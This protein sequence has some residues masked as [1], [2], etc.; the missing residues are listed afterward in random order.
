MSEAPRRPQVLE[1]DAPASRIDHE[2]EAFV[3]RPEASESAF[4]T[5]M[6]IATALFVL[7][8]GFFVVE[9]IGWI[10]SLLDTRPW[11]GWTAAGV[12]ALG[13]L[14]LLWAI[15]RE[16]AALFAVRRIE[17]WQ[18]ALALDA[19]DM[20]KARAAAQSYIALI[21]GNGIAIG[22]ARELVRGA[23]S[24]EGIRNALEKTV[25]P[26]LDKRAAQT[27][28]A[29]AAQ[30]FGMT[31]MSPSASIDALLFSLRGVRLVRQVARAYGL[32]PHGLATWELL[33][34]TMSSASLVAAADI[35]GGMLSHAILTNP[36]AAKIAG[37]VAGAAVASQRMY[38]L[39]NIASAACRLF[40]KRSGT[41]D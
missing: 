14:I 28:R 29:A 2:W 39:G 16:L 37:E 30:S 4:G 3:Q 13:L 23:N 38:R 6:L 7:V 31:A 33:R 22:D 36:F 26:V 25:L 27:V 17:E 19:E 32:R 40:P 35:A 8:V 9:S 15:W 5:G 34:R 11:L 41:E 18:D 12:L 21:R 24:I 20:D 1:I 10:A